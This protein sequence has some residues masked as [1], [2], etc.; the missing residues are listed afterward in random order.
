MKYDI[1]LNLYIKDLLYIPV[2][3]LKMFIKIVKIGMFKITF[4]IN[5][6]LDIS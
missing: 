3:E 2:L 5:I 1:L 4:N 6:N